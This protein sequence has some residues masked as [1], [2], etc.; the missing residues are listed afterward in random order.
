MIHTPSLLPDESAMGYWGRVLRLNAVGTTICSERAFTARVRKHVTTDNGVRPEM[1]HVISAVAHVTPST[2]IRF[3]TLVPM[4]GA[5]LGVVNGAWCDDS[6]PC[7]ELRW[8]ALDPN[9]S[10]RMLCQ[11][12]AGEDLSFW[13]FSYWRRSHQ[14]PGLVWCQKHGCPL[15][16]VRENEAWRS[17]PHEVMRR[18]HPAPEVV[19][20]QALNNP[21]LRR[22]AGVC[23]E[24]LERARPLSTL[25]AMRTLAERADAFGLA[26]SPEDRGERLS[27]LAADRIGGPWQD[28]FWKQLSDKNRG[29]YF[30]SLDETLYRLC[31]VPDASGYA[32]AIAL[33]FESADAAFGD[34]ARPLP[35]QESLIAPIDAEALRIARNELP[36]SAEVNECRRTRMCQAVSMVLSGAAIHTAARATGWSPLVLE[37]VL[38]K[39][40]KP[41]QVS[42][43]AFPALMS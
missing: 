10:S 27:D 18:A 11:M 17:M 31:A 15:F 43:P 26:T 25:H 24:L 30:P 2:L 34:L 13:G 7:R 4:N 3:H 6:Y 33:L 22:Y 19:I 23:T 39:C 29:A 9:S 40:I 5:V 1:V 35:T 8:R 32:L 20:T 42:E 21:V 37:R 41:S 36:R 16:R 28:M 12:C 38:R 14:V